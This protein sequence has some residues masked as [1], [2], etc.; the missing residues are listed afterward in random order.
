MGPVPM[1]TLLAILSIVAGL[2]ATL[3][4]LVMIMAGGAN[5][6]PNDIRILKIAMVSVIVVGLGATIAAVTLI[7]RGKSGLAALVGLIPVVFD[8]ALVVVALVTEF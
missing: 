7:V 5:A 2:L 3:T 6:K 1:N 8:V 4:M